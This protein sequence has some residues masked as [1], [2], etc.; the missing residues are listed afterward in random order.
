MDSGDEAEMKKLHYF[1]SALAVSVLACGWVQAGEKTIFGIFWEGCEHGCQGF[2]DA[3]KNSEFD[4][5]VLIRD[6]MQDRNKLPEFIIEAREIDA[7]LVLTYGTSVTLGVAGQINNREPENFISKRPLVFMYVS[8]PFG[9][10]IAESFEGSGRPHVAGTFNRVP[11]AVNIK[12]IRTIQ[13]DFDHLGILF[14]MNERNSALKVKEMEELSKEMG[15]E[16]TA[17]EIDPGNQSVPDSA[18][19][20][21]KVA[22]L[23]DAGVDF[24]YLG[25]SSFLRLNADVFTGAAVQNGLP[26]LSP[27]EEVVREQDALLSVAARAA[28]VGALAAQQALKILRD[29]K[30]PGDLPIARVTDFAYVVNMDVAKKLGMYPP[31]ELLQIAEV[32]E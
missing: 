12:T 22:E 4:A 30:E 17:L 32:V 27:Y 5:K 19:I 8:D 24:I 2:I 6:A 20:P 25:S 13:P 7:D 14:N 11:E 26:I 31:I 29:G 28:D 3:I 15:F 10:G 18:L 9:S 16:L 21:G 23:A 1:A